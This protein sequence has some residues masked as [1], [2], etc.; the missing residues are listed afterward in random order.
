M[1]AKSSIA[2]YSVFLQTISTLTIGD[3]MSVQVGD[4]YI[5]FTL[6]DSLKE[7]H[8]LS[9]YVGKGAIVLAFFPGAFTGA[10]DR[11]VCALRDSMTR[12]NDLGAKV[13]GISV[14]G[15]FALK[16][17][18][19]KYQLN[20]ALLADFTRATIQAY[21]VEFSNLGGVEGYKCA[22][23][24]VFI[25]DNEGTVRYAWTASPNPGVEPNYEELVATVQSLNS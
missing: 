21:G 19:Q 5:D 25:I 18:S 20:F 6:V 16:E 22:N 13:F 3:A 14:D 9:S 23:R 11:E 8:T 4:H 12:Y 10:C 7:K 24:A 15:P 17:F 2:V 1:Q